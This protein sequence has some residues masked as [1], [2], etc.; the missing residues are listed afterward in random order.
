[1][2][3]WYILLMWKDNIKLFLLR[4]FNVY[5]LFLLL[6]VGLFIFIEKKVNIFGKI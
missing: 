2:Y 3:V 5:W 1:M 6:G 4:Y